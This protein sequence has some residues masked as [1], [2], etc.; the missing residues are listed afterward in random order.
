M[1]S[2]GTRRKRNAGRGVR[3]GSMGLGKAAKRPSLLDELKASTPSSGFGPVIWHERLRHY[4]SGLHQQIID[5]IDAFNANDPDILAVRSTKN[6]LAAWIVK[7]LP[8]SVQP[9]TIV[10]Y[11]NR[12][13]DES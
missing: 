3:V 10:R 12:R 8:F 6:S 7:K 11:I 1:V 5:V 13:L 2:H 4:D 9:L